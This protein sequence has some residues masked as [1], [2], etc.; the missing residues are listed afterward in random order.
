[1]SVIRVNY[2]TDFHYGEPAVL[3]ALDHPGVEEFSAVLRHADANGESTLRHDAVTHE[4][5][6]EPDAAVIELTQNL[7]V[8][9][10]DRAKVNEIAEYLDTLHNPGSGHHYVDIVSP[11]ETLVLSCNEYIGN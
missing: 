1:M 8:W 3:L 5:R 10:L 6:I 9:R 2:L 11:A 7:V 4:F